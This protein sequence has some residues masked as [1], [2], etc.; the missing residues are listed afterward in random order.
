EASVVDELLDVALADAQG[1]GDLPGREQELGGLWRG[2]LGRAHPIAGVLSE[3]ML[4]Q[5]RC[6]DCRATSLLG[7]RRDHRSSSVLYLLPGTLCHAYRSMH[8]LHLDSEHQSFE[9]A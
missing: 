3:F 8:T 7:A 6:P 5:F 2:G 9:N 1:T 4:G